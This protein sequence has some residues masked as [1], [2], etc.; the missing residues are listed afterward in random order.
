M[1]Q[2]LYQADVSLGSGIKWKKCNLSYDSAL[3]LCQDFIAK[4]QSESTVD[5]AKIQQ[6]RHLMDVFK[7]AR[8]MG[9]TFYAIDAGM[10]SFVVAFLFKKKS[11]TFKFINYCNT[12][13]AMK[14]ILVPLGEKN[15]E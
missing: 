5:F 4:Y 6:Y 2:Q 13:P 8:D 12:L 10:A 1:Y 11:T 14:A 15:G 3:K 9:G 7:T